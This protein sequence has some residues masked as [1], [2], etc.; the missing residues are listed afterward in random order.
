MVLYLRHPVY[1]TKVAVSMMEV[2]ADSENGWE[3]YTPGTPSVPDD[4]VSSNGLE[5]KR[6]RRTPPSPQGT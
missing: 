3:V 5:L 1:G 4:A 6:R 2:D